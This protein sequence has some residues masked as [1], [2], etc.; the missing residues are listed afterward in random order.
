MQKAPPYRKQSR[1]TR[2]EWEEL[3]D[4]PEN[5]YCEL[6]EVWYDNI[7]QEWV[8]DCLINLKETIS[9]DGNRDNK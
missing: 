6:I 7:M 4:I 1:Y 9:A 5:H 8:F 3:L 2:E